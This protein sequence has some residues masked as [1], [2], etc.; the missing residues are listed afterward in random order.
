M[1]HGS[2][3]AYSPQRVQS[4]YIMAEGPEYL[5]SVEKSKV[6]TSCKSMVSVVGFSRI[7]YNVQYK[8]T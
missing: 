7:D 2:T 3:L 1:N 5:H 4:S 6:L 8:A